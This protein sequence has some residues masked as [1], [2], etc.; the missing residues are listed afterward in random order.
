MRQRNMDR[1]KRIF[2]EIRQLF[3]GQTSYIRQGDCTSS[4][5]MG[6]LHLPVPNYMISGLI[7]DNPNSTPG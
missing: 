4:A 1:R 7:K 3:R 6:L 5:Y 2:C